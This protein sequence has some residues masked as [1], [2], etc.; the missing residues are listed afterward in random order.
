MSAYVSNDGGG[1]VVGCILGPREDVQARGRGDASVSWLRLWVW[2]WHPLVV[3]WIFL[4]DVASASL[5]AL[6]GHEFFT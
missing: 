1:V 6:Q 4:Q 2:L 3:I 5:E